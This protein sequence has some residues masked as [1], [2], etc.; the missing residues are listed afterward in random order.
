MAIE[1]A[2]RDQNY[3]PV[4]LGT[5]MSTGTYPTKVYVD[6]STHRLL[7]NTTVSG[8]VNVSSEKATSAGTSTGVSVGATSTTVLASNSSRKAAIIVND[9][10]EVVYLK[11]GT[12][13][14][15][16]SGIRLNASGG[17]VREE[18]YTGIIT[19]ICASGSKT[20]TVTEM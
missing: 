4:I 7:T 13:A 14:T 17:L 8:T 15:S 3:Y 9:S 6:E 1:N 10:D 5:D 12:G 2:K 16:N 20:V 11:Y 19:G 18:M